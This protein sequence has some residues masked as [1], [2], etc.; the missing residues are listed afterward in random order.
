MPELDP[1]I[2][3]RSETEP[4]QMLREDLEDTLKEYMELDLVVELLQNAL[5]AI[6]RRRYEAIASAAGL[7][8]DDV[9]TIRGWNG[10]VTALIEEDARVYE[11]ADGPADR[12]VLYRTFAD[13]AARRTRWWDVLAEQFDAS[14]ADLA[15][16]A[17]AFRGR[18]RVVVRL[19]PPHWIEV[20]DNGV[21]MPGVLECF[22]HKVSAKRSSDVR[23][24]RYGVRGSHGW[25]LT[26]VLGLSDRVEVASCRDGAEPEIFAFDDY[27]SFV[28]GS[29]AQPRT[30]GLD[31]A[32]AGNLSAAIREGSAGTH[33]RVSL[34][35]P[36]DTNQLGNT[37][38]HYGHTKFENLLR[39]YTPIGQV[40]DFVLHP[41][42]HT[43]RR[44]DVD[45]ELVS[46]RPDADPQHSNVALD[47]FR[48][49]GRT[50]PSHY[51]FKAYVD[52]NSPR[53]KSVHTLH[54][55]RFGDAVLLSGADI[56]AAEEI[57]K[58]EE[59]LQRDGQ[60]PAYRDEMDKEIATIPRG[61]Q[62][63]LSGGMRSEY[64]ARAPRGT[65]A[66]FRGVILSETARPTLGRK[67]VLD[68]R[69][70]IPRGAASH[71]SAYDAIRKAVLPAAEP[72]PATPAAA[73]W[74]REFFVK[75][76]ESLE[77][78]PPS[79]RNLATWAGQESREARV[80]LM[81]GEL[82]GRG[83]FG[84]L[85]VLRAHLRDIYDFA[86]LQTVD[87]SATSVPSAGLARHAPAAGALGTHWDEVSAL[88]YWR[89]QGDRREHLRR[90][91][92]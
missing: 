73:R 81:F 57:H 55:S 3:A 68:Q 77:S 25:G 48:L 70:S 1:F 89:V 20:E 13:D 36:L 45:V 27:A 10:A 29:V 23:P 38:N 71:E 75:V 56:Q 76:R 90:L 51:D 82:L 61:F 2:L 7:D 91:R 33:V 17:N 67:H 53:G 66:A 63:A 24:R 34:S 40:S 8:P 58:L 32:G 49:S 78:Q 11:A 62:L 4:A 50:V 22:K 37:L 54:R 88:R 83:E 21:G 42:F 28:A 80:M 69:S 14:A 47:F 15:L 35:N 6:D 43:V 64:L 26:A 44:D 79:S 39:L 18:L 9:E 65:S 12:A 19:G 41:A 87:V 16:A 92:P 85:R 59:L 31:E 84:D 86:F 46:Y 30:V 60:L 72:P 5:D 74:R 52:A